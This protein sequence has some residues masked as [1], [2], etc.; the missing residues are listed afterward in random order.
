MATKRK[1]KKERGRPLVRKYPPRVDAAPEEIAKAM[2][3]LPSDYQWQ[4]EEDGG[5]VYRCV[6]CE[7]DVNYPE[8]LYRDRRCE[9]CHDKALVS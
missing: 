8:T 1:N 4:Y 3:A 2:F 7:R 6:D 5:K 9:G